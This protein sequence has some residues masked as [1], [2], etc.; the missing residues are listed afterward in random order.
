VNLRPH[1][2]IPSCRERGGIGND[3]KLW[4]P[5]LYLTEEDKTLSTAHDYS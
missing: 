5:L 3:D 2:G 4:R 1:D